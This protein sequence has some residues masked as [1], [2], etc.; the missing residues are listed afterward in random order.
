MPSLRDLQTDVMRAILAADDRR[1]AQLVSAHGIAAARRLGIYAN[2]ARVN[3]YESLRASFPAIL[4]LVGEDYFH[5]CACEFQ[6]RYPSKCGDLQYT[7]THFPDYLGSLHAHD[8]FRYLGDVGRLEWLRQEALLSAD[9]RPLDLGKLAAVAPSDYAELRFR[10]HP[11]TRMLLSDYPCLKIW[12]ANV[13]SDGEPEVID[14]A[15]GPDRLLLTRKTMQVEVH[16]LSRGEQ[17]FLIAVRQGVRL[18]EAVEHGM[19]CDGEFNAAA[20]LQRFVLVGA[21]VDLE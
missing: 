1:A 5:Q 7:G 6:K 20:A 13:G 17:R 16:R 8:E 21:I 15:M 14:L 12:Q 2:N 10:L 11:A 4:R 3:F 9:H 19:E 18:G